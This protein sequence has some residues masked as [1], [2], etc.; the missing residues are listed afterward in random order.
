M[1]G[2]TKMRFLSFALVRSA[3]LLAALLV[4][5]CVS[6]GTTAPATG[7]PTTGPGQAGAAT[8]VPATTG[9]YLRTWQ[10]QALAPDYT[11]GSLPLATISDGEY[12]DGLVAIPMIFPGP[13]YVGLSERPI[14]SA[15]IDAIVAEAQADGLLGAT[16]DFSQGLMPG[17]VTAHVTIVVD[18][19]THDL[20]GLLPGATAPATV[21]PGTADAFEA[22]WTKLSTID[23]WLAADLGSSTPYTPTSV[24]VMLTAPTDAPAGMTPQIKPW[25]LSSTFATFGTAMG[26]SRCG[27]VSGPDLATLLPVVQD[28]NALTRFT[29]STGATTSIEVRVIVP[30]EPGPC[31]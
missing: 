18:G 26:S 17:G 1:A 13:I 31:P 30:G 6:P 2:S 16:T 20:T 21:K 27:V 7:A 22:F 10:S 28:S 14:S 15:G 8:P 5:G 25:P 11:F 29:D 24:A 4:A 12:I 3:P 23:E 19:T 9:F